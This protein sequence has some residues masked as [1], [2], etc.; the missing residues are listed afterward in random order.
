MPRRKGKTSNEN[1]TGRRFEQ[2]S[3]G[4]W[5]VCQLPRG[6]L[7]TFLDDFSEHAQWS[8]LLAQEFIADT[9]PFESGSFSKSGHRVQTLCWIEQKPDHVNTWSPLPF[10]KY[11]ALFDE[12]AAD[13]WPSLQP[14]VVHHCPLLYVG[15]NQRDRP[16]SRAG[17]ATLS[18]SKKSATVRF[19][20]MA[21][22]RRL[23]C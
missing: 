16:A 14:K 12:N 22:C 3:V 2:L 11:F 17:R 9:R 1:Y 20:C 7:D 21:P 10:T 8:I 5:N 18:R 23:T 15:E 13:R 4:C 6:L 19:G